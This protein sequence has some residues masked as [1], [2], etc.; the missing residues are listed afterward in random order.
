M[1]ISRRDFCSLVGA[2][3]PAT[4]VGSG[5]PTR[6]GS[7]PDGP[8]RL[9]SN[10][11]P[12]GPSPAARAAFAKALI[13]G[14][15][16]P[17]TQ[18]LTES[19][20]RVAG[21]ADANVLV[22]VGATEALTICARAF[23]DPGKPLVTAAPTYSAIASATESLGHPVVRVP[24]RPDGPLD[25]D[26]MADRAKGAGVVYLCNPNNPTGVLIPSATIAQFI[27]RVNAESPETVMVFGEA[28]HEYLD[29]AEYRSAAAEALANPRV[30]VTRTFSK[31]YGL[32]G[33]RLGYLLGHQSTIQRLAPLRVPIGANGPG[34]A[35]AIAAL[36]DQPE[37]FRQ[38][39]L[40]T[41]GR[42]A[43]ERFFA[44]RGWRAYPA[45]A[46]Y[47]FI[48]I[49][50]DLVAFRAACQAE[51]LLIGR[52]YPPAET[53]ARL[54]IGTPNEMRRGLAILD[55]LLGRA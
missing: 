15:R 54:T 4:M 20:A 31:L 37:L 16:Y 32:A 38:R 9:D 24:I 33:I 42:V 35:A 27:T 36:G 14:G 6:L 55:R 1:S 5:D 25:L 44:E 45:S 53:W 2:G 19:I 8:I 13:D 22:T 23:T 52:L 30:V 17:G 39:R 12:Y 7:A 40:N 21:A 10:E 48:D 49:K 41:E 18:P 28:Y 46:N 51:G 26:Q 11:N 47:L 43:A 50:R 34:I 3:V 29:Q